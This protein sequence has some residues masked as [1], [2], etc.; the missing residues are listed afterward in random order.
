M[1]FKKNKLAL[2]IQGSHLYNRRKN[3]SSVLEENVMKPKVTPST[4]QPLQPTKHHVS[5]GASEDSD[6]HDES[7]GYALPYSSTNSALHPKSLKK[8]NTV[9]E[10]DLKQVNPVPKPPR[11]F[12][13]VKISN[14]NTDDVKTKRI[15]KMG[16]PELEEEFRNQFI[17]DLDLEEALKDRPPS[18][19]PPER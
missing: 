2:E 17:K 7:P 11:M 18:F 3:V 9:I 8:Q 5:P 19:T 1:S 10:S 14:D 12:A 13:Q 16:P 15:T 6:N 4:S